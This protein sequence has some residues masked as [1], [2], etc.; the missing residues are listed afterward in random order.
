MLS[1]FGSSTGKKF[2][3]AV[4]GAALF[5]FIVGHLL[6]NLQVFLGPEELNRYSAFLHNT[7]ELLW[8]ARIGLLVMVIV[9]IWTATS[10]TLEN[11]AARPVPYAA[12]DYIEASYA[13]RTMHWSGVIVVAYLIYHLMHFTFRSVHPELTHFTNEQG[14]PDVY[15]MVVM[16]FQRPPIAITYI[17]ANFLLGM[18]LSH[19]LYSAFQSLGLLTDDLRVRL[20]VL[21]HLVGYGIFLGYASIPLGVLLGWVGLPW[22]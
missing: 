16:S 11:R 17:L 8:F 20:R 13:S 12:K 6:G 3:M 4:S 7:G 21:A 14:R 5:A 19:G 18:H 10:L 22:S 15:R 2:L 9:H 1:Y